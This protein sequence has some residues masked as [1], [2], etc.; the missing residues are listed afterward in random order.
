MDKDQK[1]DSG[2]FYRALQYIKE[3][4]VIGYSLTLLLLVPAAFFANNYIANTNYEKAIDTI[5]QREAVLAENIFGKF[6]YGQLAD[7]A[8][9]QSSIDQIM[10]GNSDI[11]S[12]SVLRPASEQGVFEVAASSD[13]E[14]VG[15]TRNQDV[16]N[17]LAWSQ[18]EG[19]AFLDQGQN[20]R[21]WT[22]TKT[23]LDPD[24]AKIGLV[25]MSLSLN[26]SDA[27]V[28][29][30]ITYS[31]WVLAL[32]ILALVLL[33]ANQIRLLDYAF[34]LNKL[35]EVDKMKDMFISMASHELRAPLAAIKGYLDLM[36]S[37]KGLV[38]GGESARYFENIA[39]SSG[40]LERLVED[41]LEVSRLEGNRFPLEIAEFDPDPMIRQSVEEMR[42]QAIKKNLALEYVPVQ[43]PVAVKAD[44]SRVKQVVI[45]LIGNALKYTD[46]GA[47][48]I[49]TAVNKDNFLITVADTG[50]GIS[51]E[52]QANLFQKFYRVKN[53][54]TKNILGTGLG[55]WI[56]ME[57]VKKMKGKITV[58]SIESVGTHFTVHLPLAKAY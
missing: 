36:K 23:I 29:G 58:E 9:L 55:L 22:V 25:E 50:I 30:V 40:R 28:N 6:V 37:D 27:I 41:M 46:K 47:I 51:S 10:R 24:D 4:I 5:T 33:L 42:S 18:P 57:T 17:I 56:T 31:Y 21:F 1:N 48:K 3:N 20:G 34:S 44:A 38:L 11:L 12:L 43:S 7:P 19:I 54:K 49:T 14:Q 39:V 45:N 2:I 52:E 35:K 26:G 32:T 53:E 8:A 16:Q 15:Q 13:P